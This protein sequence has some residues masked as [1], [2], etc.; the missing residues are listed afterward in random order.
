MKNKK[1]LS[2]LDLKGKI[3]FYDGYDY[4]VLR[5]KK[6]PNSLWGTKLF[7]DLSSVNCFLHMFK[8]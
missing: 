7:L 8:R 6:I 1:Q 2:L 3:D 4:K 5:S